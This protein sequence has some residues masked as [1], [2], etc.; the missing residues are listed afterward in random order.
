GFRLFPSLQCSYYFIQISL[1]LFLLAIYLSSFKI[2]ETL[3]LQSHAFPDNPIIELDEIDS[4]NNYAMGLLNADK[5]CMGLTIV[6]RS[7]TKGKG[8]RGR[9]WQDQPGA[10]LSMSM[11]VEPERGLDAQFVFIAQVALAVADA[12]QGLDNNMDV[13]IK[14]PNDI[15]INDKKAGGILIEN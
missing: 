3:A 13:A 9:V 11:I 5:A 14:W 1:Y 12:L 4:T 2:N 10:S 6:A 8:Q 15:I 7:Q